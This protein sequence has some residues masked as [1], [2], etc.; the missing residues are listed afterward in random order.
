MS[1]C[2]P[3]G[4]EVVVAVS[5]DLLSAIAANML[6]D[7]QRVSPAQEL[8]ALGE[9]ANVVCGNLLPA[10]AGEQAAFRIGA[11]EV[12]AGPGLP[13]ADAPPSAHVYMDLDGG[14]A[15]LWL[16]LEAAA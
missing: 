16:F 3:F 2:G 15:D 7:E 8:D 14:Q 9:V 10:I 11:P 1:F 4:G 12:A 5:A 13:W 6:G